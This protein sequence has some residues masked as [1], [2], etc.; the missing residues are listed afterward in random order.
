M[1]QVRLSGTLGVKADMHTI[2]TF[3]FGEKG[4]ASRE[5]IFALVRDYF[6]DDTRFVFD[7]KEM[8]FG[9]PSQLRVSF[10]S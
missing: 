10:E 5:E 9:L 4:D 2:N 3:L 1:R 8:P 6:K 7:L